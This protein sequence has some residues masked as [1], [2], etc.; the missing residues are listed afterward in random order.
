MSNEPE[1]AN[2]DPEIVAIQRD[3]GVDIYD[4]DPEVEMIDGSHGR[5][6]FYESIEKA[7]SAKRA[8]LNG[9]P[10][11]RLTEKDRASEA[12]TRKLH[13]PIS[14]Q[15]EYGAPEEKPIEEMTAREAWQRT[16]HKGSG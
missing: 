9:A 4:Q 2:S 12:W 11:E 5:R 3:A 15:E 10:D 6:K 1:D 13:K 8:R 14:G 16:T 7:A